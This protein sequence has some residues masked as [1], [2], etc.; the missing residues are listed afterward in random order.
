MTINIPGA[1]QSA[2]QGNM[3]TSAAVE[4]PFPAPAFYIVNGDAKLAALKNVQ[5]FGGWACNVEKLRESADNYDN[6]PYPIPGFQPLEMVADDGKMYNVLSA[7]SLVVA[8]IGMRQFS[9]IKDASGNKKRVPPFTKGARPGIQVLC[10]LGYRNEQKQIL[11]WA[12]VMLSANGYQ[13]NHIQKSINSWRKAIKP[14]VAK[15]VPGADDSILNLFYMHI[16]TFGDKRKAEP[17]GEKSITPVS[18]YIPEDLDEKKVENMYVGEPMAEFMA[19]ISIKA[20]EWLKVFSNMEKP[21]AQAQAAFR[22][23]PQDMLYE[24]PPFPDDDQIPF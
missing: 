5:Y 8:T 14:H 24:E 15:L 4:L 10:V 21:Q 12:P 6:V 2:F 11:P 9:T 22:N 1:A 16:G 3:Q 23:Q 18:A 7:R 13:V 20:Q 17:A 19:D